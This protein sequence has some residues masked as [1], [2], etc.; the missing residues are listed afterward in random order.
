MASHNQQNKKTDLSII[1]PVYNEAE[2]IQPLHRMIK[3]ILTR[4]DKSYEII[5]VDDGSRD[6]TLSILSELK[7]S[8]DFVI[9][10]LSRNFGQTAALS[11]AIDAASGKIIVMLDGD[12]Q[13]DPK[14]I[15]LLLE[16]IDEGYDVVS[17]WRKDRKDS[18]ITRIL[19]S[20]IA[21]RLISPLTGV[22]LTDYGCTLKD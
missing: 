13:N 18:F 1:V 15:K 3:E 6:D 14:D 22:H 9:V 5:F 17:G 2:N 11:A 10:Q 8:E 21:N 16:K 4:L 7:R 20:R 19:P 12:L